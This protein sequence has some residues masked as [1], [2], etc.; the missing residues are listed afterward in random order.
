LSD[1]QLVEYESRLVAIPDIKRQKRLGTV[2]FRQSCVM[3]GHFPR[4][5]DVT[6]EDSERPAVHAGCRFVHSMIKK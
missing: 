4:L 6:V 5:Y 1:D 3:I 2:R